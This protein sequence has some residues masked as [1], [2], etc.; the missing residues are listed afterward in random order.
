MPDDAFERAQVLQWMFFEQ[1]D[2][3]PA[4]AV[5]R[6][7]VAY[8]GRPE[9]YRRPARGAH[10]RRPPRAGRDGAAPR[11]REFLVGAG[12]TL[13]D[14]A[15]YAYT[16]VAHEGGFDL[17]A[18]PRAS[19][20]GSTGSPRCPA[21]CRSTPS[22]ARAE[23][24]ESRAVNVLLIG[25][26]GREHALAWSS[27]R[28]RCSTSCTRRRAT[29]GSRGSGAATPCAPRTPRACSTSARPSGSTSSWSGPEQP[30][31]AGV[32]D[33]LRHA[34]FAV[35]GPGRGGGGDRGLEAL[36]EGRRLAGVPAPPDQPQRRASTSS[37]G[38]PLRREGRRARRGQGRVHVPTADEL[39]GRPRGGRRA[40]RPGRGRG[41]AR[42]RRG[43]R[44]RA[45]RRRRRSSPL[46]AARDHKRIGDG[47]TGPEHRRHGRVHA[48]RRHRPR[49]ARRTPC[50]ARSPPS[51]RA[52]ARPSSAC[53]SPG[54]CS[55][56]DGPRVL[57]FN[58]RFGDPETQVILP[59]L[60]GD[61][62]A[63]CAAAARGELPA[64]PMS[65]R[66]PR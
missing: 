33:E 48:G 30:L 31:V 46:A 10:G 17:G 57:E 19:R 27:R 18:V 59:L 64:L 47:D 45:R 55:R 15:L 40:G 8:S 23:T 26:G 5:V 34:G 53:S 41:V 42:G 36:R 16:H 35:F 37:R 62:L 66:A 43:L 12:P 9:A 24:V 44:L 65:R 4:I 63:A 50:T 2:H 54:S 49:R 3:E 7:W 39:R 6:F 20:P 52:A 38:R 32:A 56:A 51:S 60:E 25:S 21:T 58:C 22:A 1:Y 13:A 61:L 29:P 11:G 14:I 28:A